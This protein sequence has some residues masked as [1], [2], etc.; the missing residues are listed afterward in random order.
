MPRLAF[1]SRMVA[2][3]Q[4]FDTYRDARLVWITTVSG[5]RISHG[6][7]LRG[8]YENSKPRSSFEAGLL[9]WPASAFTPLAANNHTSFG[10]PRLPNAL[11]KEAHFG[12]TLW[13]CAPPGFA[14]SSGV[15]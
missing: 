4:G 8:A 2:T 1:R 5:K 6:A 14:Q 15:P 11:A 10:K 13:L 7:C 9:F 3:T 12:I